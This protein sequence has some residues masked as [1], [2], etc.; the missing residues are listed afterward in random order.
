MTITSKGLT[1]F[2]TRSNCSIIAYLR[3]LSDILKANSKLFRQRYISFNPFFEAKNRPKRL[4]YTNLF[5]NVLI[6]FQKSLRN[7]NI[8]Y[9]R[10]ATKERRGKQTRVIECIFSWLRQEKKRRLQIKHGQLNNCS[11]IFKKLLTRKG[12]LRIITIEQMFKC[13]REQAG[14]W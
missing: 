4:E 2:L 1:N 10:A 8:L 11:I 6:Y 14:S 3:L 7:K 5:K 12:Q 13:L 9:G